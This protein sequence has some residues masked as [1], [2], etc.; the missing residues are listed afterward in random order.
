MAIQ[1]DDVEM[2]KNEMKKKLISI[3]I[4]AKMTSIKIPFYRMIVRVEFE[5]YCILNYVC[6]WN[7][8]GSFEILKSSC[9]Y[10]KGVKAMYLNHLKNHQPSQ[11]KKPAW[12]FFKYFRSKTMCLKPYSNSSSKYCS[13]NKKKIPSLLTWNNNKFQ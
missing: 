10:F 9:I 12:F 5:I 2:G 6:Q 3:C 7:K 8:T 13:R 1:L 4:K 11:K